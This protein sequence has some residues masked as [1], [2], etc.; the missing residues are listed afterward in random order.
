[1]C[2]VRPATNSITSGIPS[3]FRHM[4]DMVGAFLAESLK[5]GIIQFGTVREQSD[6]SDDIT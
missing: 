6:D 4:V 5:A 3:T 1:M 2:L